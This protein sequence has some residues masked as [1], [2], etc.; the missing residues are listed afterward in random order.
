MDN[1][2][3]M[4]REDGATVTLSTAGMEPVVIDKAGADRI[5]AVAKDAKSRK[6]MKDPG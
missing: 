1:V 4:A 6:R 2:A 3:K 5:H